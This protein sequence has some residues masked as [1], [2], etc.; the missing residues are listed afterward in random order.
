[1]VNLNTGE[2]GIVSNARLGFVGRPVV[3]ICY[4]KELMELKK[5]YD[6]DLAESQHQHRLV[7]AVLEY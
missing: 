6:I 5:P 4:D 7:E 1:M 3:R 2:R